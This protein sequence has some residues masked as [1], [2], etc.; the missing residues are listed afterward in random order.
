MYKYRSD[1]QKNRVPVTIFFPGWLRFI[2]ST[3]H[4]MS[5]SVKSNLVPTHTCMLK[6]RLLWVNLGRIQTPTPWYCWCTWSGWI[7]TL[8]M[9]FD[10]WPS[11]FK[12][13][14]ET[15]WTHVTLCKQQ[16]NTT[17]QGRAGAGENAGQG[18]QCR[19][20]QAL[21][22]A[23]VRGFYC[24]KIPDHLTAQLDAVHIRYT[25]CLHPV[26]ILLLQVL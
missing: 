4:K 11:T 10:L 17:G 1:G 23:W 22:E 8:P 3:H 12:T 20:I 9:T 24:F 25:S 6:C 21:T 16:T 2:C 13:C 14:E 19:S 18:R 5:K 15:C 7:Q 26:H